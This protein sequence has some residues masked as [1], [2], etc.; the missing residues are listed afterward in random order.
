MR[1]NN[2]NK[3]T[4]NNNNNYEINLGGSIMENRTSITKEEFIRN[5]KLEIETM[6]ADGYA[7]RVQEVQKNNG[8]ILNGLTILKTGVN[9]APTIYLDSFYQDYKNGR[10]LESIVDAVSVTYEQHKVEKKFSVDMISDFDSVKDKIC[11]K[12]INAEKNNKLLTEIPYVKFLDLAIVFYILLDESDDGNATVLIRNGMMHMWGDLDVDYIYE[13]A[14]KNTQRLFIGHVATMLEVVNGIIAEN[15]ELDPD[16]VD[17]FFSMNVK[18]E[19]FMPMY[20]ATNKSR[21]N[22]ATA[23]LYDGLLAKFAEKVGCNFYILPSS[24][25]ETILLPDTGDL[26]VDYLIEMVRSVNATEV[27]PEEILSDNVYKYIVDE[28]RMEMM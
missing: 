6:Y 2:I 25:H 14:K 8:L 19:K 27:S 10:T 11:F 1:K 9:I 13:I 23:I 20:V 16:M 28:D 12:L 18:G 26:D 3:G 7:V 22:G 15:A 17:A 24:I 4:N 5:V 21:L